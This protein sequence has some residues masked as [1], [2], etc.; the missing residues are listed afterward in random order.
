VTSRDVVTDRGVVRSFRPDEWRT[1]RA[2]RLQS[3]EDSPDAFGSTLA[4]ELDF[5]DDT[6][7]SRLTKGVHSTHDLPLVA[8]LSDEPVGLCWGRIVADAPD[9]VHLYQMWIAPNA[10][11]H[12]LAL[13]MLDTA[14]AWARDAGATTVELDVTCG[15]T[16]A[17]RLYERAGFRPVGE[18]ALLRDG[19]ALRS[20]RMHRTLDVD[21]S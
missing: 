9:V 1:Y 8:E 11:R 16:P 21:A 4:R 6:W 14:V 19:E 18:P 17:A 10:R 2:L 15:N 20:Q 5:P 3:L 7:S 13:R 12:G